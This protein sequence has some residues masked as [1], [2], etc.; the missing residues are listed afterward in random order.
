MILSLFHAKHP[1]VGQPVTHNG[2]I[3]GYVTKAGPVSSP[4][5][6]LTLDIKARDANIVYE[7][8]LTHFSISSKGLNVL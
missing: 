8:N 2:V 6:N 7:C 1:I 4:Y 3:I 5:E